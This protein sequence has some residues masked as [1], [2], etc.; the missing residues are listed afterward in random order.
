MACRVLVEA[1][2]A[3]VLP[4]CGSSVASQR[5]AIRRRWRIA[6]RAA[7]VQG[8]GGGGGGGGGGGEGGGGGGG[9]GVL[10]YINY[11]RPIFACRPPPPDHVVGG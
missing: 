5:T 11:P 10:C 9:G 7:P 3:A 2:G 8:A 1:A 6:P 4:G